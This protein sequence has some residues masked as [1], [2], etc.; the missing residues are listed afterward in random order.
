MGRALWVHKVTVCCPRRSSMVPFHSADVQHFLR[1]FFPS[2]EASHALSKWNTGFSL[3]PEILPNEQQRLT[4]AARKSCPSLQLR[5]HSQAVKKLL[6]LKFCHKRGFSL[7]IFSGLE[8]YKEVALYPEFFSQ[9]RK[10]DRFRE[11]T[12]EIQ[13]YMG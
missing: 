8:M 11:Y 2:D 13:C 1:L 6:I 4:T 10:A 9:I 5:V 7:V 3:T 12:C